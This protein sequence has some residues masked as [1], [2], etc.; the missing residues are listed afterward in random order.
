MADKTSERRELSISGE[1]RSS[2][3]GTTYDMSKTFD[4]SEVV[5]KVGRYVSIVVFVS[6]K[7]KSKRSF[8]ISGSDKRYLPKSEPYEDEGSIFIPAKKMTSASGVAYIRSSTIDLEYVRQRFGTDYSFMLVVKSQKKD[9][10]DARSIILKPS[11]A[12]Y[13]PG[14]ASKGIKGGG[15]RGQSDGSSSP[16]EDDIAL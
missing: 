1:T 9:D 13:L 4:L 2:K 6:K 16:E 12:K 15:Y 3:T 7:D 10:P 5:R 8:V 11:S 14:S